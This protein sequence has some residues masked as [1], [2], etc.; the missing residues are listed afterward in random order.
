MQICTYGRIARGPSRKVHCV[1]N[2]EEFTA[3]P[4]WGRKCVW[5]PMAKSALPK[6]KWKG[7]SVFGEKWWKL[8]GYAKSQ[9]PQRQNK[10]SVRKR[11]ARK[12]MLEKYFMAEA[13]EKLELCR[14]CFWKAGIWRSS[15]EELQWLIK[16]SSIDKELK[17]EFQKRKKA[18]QKPSADMHMWKD[19]SGT[20]AQGSFCVK[21]RR[22]Q[23]N[24]LLG[25][26]NVY[27][28]QWP[29]SHFQKKVKRDVC[30]GDKKVSS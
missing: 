16:G 19:C 11:K 12:H 2:Q 29:N 26:E 9:E 23:S 10:R 5:V 15:I 18:I 4:C 22:V 7:M 14:S 21:S 30:F 27:G 13:V 25:G 28:C 3:I 1:P 8:F 24:S 20:L 6:K 17:K